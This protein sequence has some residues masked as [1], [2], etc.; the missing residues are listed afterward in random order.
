MNCP[1]KSAAQGNQ[2][3]MLL[4][5]CIGVSIMLLAAGIGY[6][7]SP[8]TDV[9]PDDFDKVAVRELQSIAAAASELLNGYM[10]ARVTDMLVCSKVSGRLRD[11]LPLWDEARS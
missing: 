4:T 9:A 5:F 7:R 3:R 1:E 10:D 6:S 2:L 11:A 8:K